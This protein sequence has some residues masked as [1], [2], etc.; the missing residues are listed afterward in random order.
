MYEC[1]LWSSGGYFVPGG[2]GVVVVG[3][4]IGVS[5]STTTTYKIK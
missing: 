4:G 5:T 1:D 2:G 3:V